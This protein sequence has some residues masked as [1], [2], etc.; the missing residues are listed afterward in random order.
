MK[1]LEQ[2]MK[3][4]LVSE[5]L[6]A[7]LAAAFGMLASLLAAIGLYGMMA[8]SVSRRTQEIGVRM[9]LGADRGKVVSLVM[10]EILV[11]LGLGAG[12]GLPLAVALSSLIRAQLFGISPNDPVTI[13]LAIA[14]IAFVSL[15]AGYLP[16]LRATR[17]DPI[18]ALRWE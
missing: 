16:A 2:Q 13:V 6:M 7:M 17:I 18:S 8:Y 1:S 12:I 4:S 5:R 10:Q 3:Y 11:L 14:E 15:I 9:A